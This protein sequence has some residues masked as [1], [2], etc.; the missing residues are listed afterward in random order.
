MSGM[1]DAAFWGLS[2]MPKPVT[3]AWCEATRLSNTAA[4]LSMSS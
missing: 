4:F 1:S 3:F 2:E